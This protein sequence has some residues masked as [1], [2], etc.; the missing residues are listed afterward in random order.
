MM[1][2][3]FCF[4]KDFFGARKKERRKKHH[5][6]KRNVTLPTPYDKIFMDLYSFSPREWMEIAT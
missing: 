2:I 4:Y 3:V 5:E 1:Y 6:N